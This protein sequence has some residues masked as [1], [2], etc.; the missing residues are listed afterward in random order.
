MP[1]V[2]ACARDDC[3]VL[4][5]G[6]FCLEHEP[7][8]KRTHRTAVARLAAASALLAA[9]AAGATLRAHLGR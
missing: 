8:R 4:T 3:H 5:M 6:R 1:M 9:G 7:P 2:H